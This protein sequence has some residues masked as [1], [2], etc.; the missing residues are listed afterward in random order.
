MA[1]LTQSWE[2]VVSNLERATARL[3]GLPPDDILAVAQAMNDRSIA[4]ARLREFAAQPPEPISPH[5]LDRLKEDCKSGEAIATNLLLLRAA[6][7]AEFSR[8]AEASFVLR[9]L[10]NGS[11]AARHRVNCIA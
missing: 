11:A 10:D 9:S 8:F 2:E 4:V 3:T 5:L 6:A 7:R 1:P